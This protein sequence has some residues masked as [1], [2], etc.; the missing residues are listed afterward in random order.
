MGAF[1]IPFPVLSCIHRGWGRGLM[2]IPPPSPEFL[3]NF[4]VRTLKGL[5]LRSYQ[6]AFSKAAAMLKEAQKGPHFFWASSIG[7]IIGGRG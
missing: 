4:C 6:V 2:Q 5:S 7:V 3:A 1:N